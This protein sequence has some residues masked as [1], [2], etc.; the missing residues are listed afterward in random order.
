VVIVG[1]QLNEQST[2][3]REMLMAFA[4][5]T[6]VLVADHMLALMISISILP[7]IDAVASFNSVSFLLKSPHEHL[8]SYI[9]IAWACSTLLGL[10][11]YLCEI[12]VVCWVLFYDFSHSAAWLA[13]MVLFLVLIFLLFAVHFYLSLVKHNYKVTVPHARGFG[14]LNDCVEIRDA[15]VQTTD[16]VIASNSEIV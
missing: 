11:L 10:P 1:V 15:E 2:V 16:E 5:C 12:A 3:P 14:V 9:E 4:V 6:T 13:C 7:Y 8:H